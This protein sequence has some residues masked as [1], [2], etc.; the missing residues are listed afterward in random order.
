MN[1]IRLVTFLSS[2]MLFLLFG[3]ESKAQEIIIKGSVYDLEGRLI[4]GP[5][6]YNKRTYLGTF[7]SYDGSFSFT[8][9]KTDTLVFAAF[10]FKN[11]EWCFRDSMPKAQYN[12]RV[13]LKALQVNVG[14]AEVVAP[15]E[16][17][18]IHRELR[19]LGYDERDFRLSGVDAFSSPITFLYEQ[20]SR[21]EKSKR[22]A[23][24]LEYEAEKRD[25]LKA[26]LT[27]YVEFDI[28]NLN[29]EQF[30]DFL[31]F[32]SVPDELLKSMT[33]YEFA[34]YIKSRYRDFKKRMPTLKESDFDYHD[35]RSDEKGKKKIENEGEK[36]ED[37]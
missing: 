16:V 8:A 1:A 32:C 23:F 15:M 10:G 25:L 36:L 14:V 4:P 11:L 9:Q 20:F 28:V 17:M 29:E 35:S 13:V 3:I 5:V 30:D 34:Q 2:L 6:I 24:R 19:K 21:L 7:G 31:D 18:E 22:K 26:L 33:Q 12:I 27:R 37:E